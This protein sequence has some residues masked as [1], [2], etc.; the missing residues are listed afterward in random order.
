MAFLYWLHRR[1]E[2]PSPTDVQCYWK[3]SKLSRTNKE[4]LK[5]SD[6]PGKIV[7]PSGLTNNFLSKVVERAPLNSEIQLLKY[8][9]KD[10]TR[11]LTENGSIFH[12]LLDFKQTN[13]NGPEKFIDFCTKKLSSETCE[14]IFKKSQEQA[15]S[16]L[17]HEMRYGRIT[18]SNIY[19]ASRCQTDDG[20]LC[21]IILGASSPFETAATARGKKLEKKVLSVIQKVKKIKIHSAGIQLSPTNPIFGASPD[22]ISDN[23][24]IEIKCPSKEAT[25]KNY[26]KNNE[27]SKKYKAQIMLQMHMCNK[28]KGLFC[29]AS[30]NFEENDSVEILEIEYNEI[31]INDLLRNANNFWKKS[32]FPKLICD[33]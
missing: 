10:E 14:F 17:W 8:Y 4:F 15:N 5:C 32:I 19:E 21:N 33:L 29:I 31:Y 27:I 18:A 20:S 1:S 22:G 28:K 13:E 11:M 30:P 6:F 7:S 16:S 9:K 24:C 3:K 12:L 26:I 2:E 25:V 23:F